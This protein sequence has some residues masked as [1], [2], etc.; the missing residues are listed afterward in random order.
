MNKLHTHY[1]NLKVARDAPPE[2]IKAAYKT[3]CHKFH[4]DRHAGSEWATQTFQLINSAYEVL[5]DPVRR[6][7]H[8]AWITRQEAAHQQT[9]ST[10][11]AHV[12]ATAEQAWWLRYHKLLKSIGHAFSSTKK[13][14]SRLTVTVALWVSISLLGVVL[15]ILHHV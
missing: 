2:V 4:P 14:N 13:R 15:A 5:S 10:P 1:D 6:S 8:D 9:Q 3:L 12:P 7:H 11:T